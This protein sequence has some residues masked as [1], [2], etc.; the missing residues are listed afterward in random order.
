MKQNSNILFTL[1]ILVVIGVAALYIVQSIQQATKQAFSPVQQ[2]N[3]SL[4]TQVA[5]LLHPTPT[6]IADPITYINEIRAVARLETIEYTVE[7]V[8]A[9]ENNQGTL[10]FAFGNKILVQIHGTV[11][12]GIDMQKLGPADMQY[13][14]SVLTV[15]LPQ[16]E[17]FHIELNPSKTQVYTLQ[18]GVFVDI[19]PN[20]VIG[21]LQ[22]G[23][24]KIRQAAIEDGIL[25]QAQTNAEAYLTKFFAALGYPNTIF[26]K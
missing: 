14:N 9:G 26:V 6:I 13:Q 10:A 23:E 17:I 8:V 21:A 22:G 11:S 25:Q 15:K 1:L 5:D 7:Q 16:A 3:S 19:D 12:A 20:L 4:Q 2:A 18:E 24:D